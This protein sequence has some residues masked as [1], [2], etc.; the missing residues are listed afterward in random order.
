MRM[1]LGLL[2]GLLLLATAA[3]LYRL[4]DQSIWFD[5]GWSAYAAVQPALSAVI[6]ADPTNPPL[7]YVLLNLAARGFGDTEFALRYVSLLLGVLAIPLSYQLGRR[8]FSSCAG[9]G[10]AFLVAFSPLLWWAS[11]EA[12]M[13]TLLAVLV[14]VAALAWHQLLRRPTRWAWLALWAAELAL[15]YAHNTGPI[16]ALWLNAVTFL[17]W[18][19]RVIQKRRYRLLSFPPLD[20]VG[21]RHASSTNIKGEVLTW[22][23]GQFFVALLWLPWFINR[24]LLLPEAN[25]ALRSAPA[26]SLELFYQLWAALWMGSWTMVIQSDYESVLY[27]FL[28]FFLLMAS[29]L[30]IPWH[31]TA[32]RWLI[33]HV[34]VLTGGLI[35]GLGLLGNEMHGR[36][37]VMIAPLFLVLVGAGLGEGVAWQGTN[38]ALTMIRILAYLAA[39]LFLVTFIISLVFNQNPAYQHDDARGMVQYYADNLT[40]DDTVLAWSYADRYELAYYWDRLDVQARRVTLPEGADLDTILPLLPTSGDIA[41]NVWYTQRADFRGMMSCLLSNG[42]VNEP[43]QVAFYGMTN[44]LYRSPA[45]DLPELQSAD[46]AIADLA[47]L[48]AVGVLPSSTGDKALCLPLQIRLSQPTSADLKAALIVH[49]SLG[50]EIARDDAPF[51]DAAQRTTS[52]LESGTVLTAYPLLRLPPGTPPGQYPV[53]LR[54]YDEQIQPSGYDFFTPG[55]RPTR[56]LPLGVWTIETGANWSEVNRTSD[57]PVKR[58]LPIGDD[59]TLIADNVQRG[60]LRNGDEIRLVLLWRGDGLLPDLTLV[61]RDGAWSLTIP[62]PA[63]PNRDDL[64]F[65]WRAVRIPLD[66][67]TGVAELRLPDGT[68][69]GEYAVESVPAL[70]NAPEFA[71]PVGAKFPG[72]G[73]LVGYTLETDSLDRTIPIDVTLIWRGDQTPDLSYTVFVQLL[74]PDGQVIA[75]ADSIPAANT[76]PTSGWRPGEYIVD[77]QQLTFHPDAQPGPARLIV[78]LYDP[79]T[80]ARVPLASGDDFVLLREEI[81][82]H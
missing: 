62:A 27:V 6:D 35:L 29:I 60:A 19:I 1:R 9:V 25:S 70:Y 65:D 18:A 73:T 61:D 68:V 77:V 58:D 59:L 55:N 82:V 34:V 54:I 5:E 67:K 17:A 79:A 51:A 15:L 11:Q 50:W 44:Q 63:A 4:G 22:F 57:L 37:L 46:V 23:A 56:D 47:Q 2:I 31:K 16:I 66:A 21:T 38:R 41:L 39:T 71:A 53:F 75:Q 64:F 8:L 72:V 80:G 74:N 24:F 36:Y 52:A 20:A 12:R 76:R 13:Y 10:A 81:T 78:G 14:L 33:T 48:T 69:L 42:T 43:E 49:N 30:F 26:F 40:A 32:A 3:R 45:L 7:Y 28:L